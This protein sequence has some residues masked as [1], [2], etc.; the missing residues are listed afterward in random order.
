MSE[1]QL[2]T[3]VGYFL[4]CKQICQTCPLNRPINEGDE[5]PTFCE[6]L[7]EVAEKFPEGGDV[8]G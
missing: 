1:Q 8:D 6:L 5:H 2:M 3:A 4:Q 7:S